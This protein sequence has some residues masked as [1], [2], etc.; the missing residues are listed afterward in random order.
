MELD[1]ITVVLPDLEPDA[2]VGV[3]VDAT[4]CCVPLTADD[5]VAEGSLAAPS[6]AALVEEVLL[7]DPFAAALVAL[8]ALLLVAA[9]PA[10]LLVAVA[11]AGANVPVE[12]SALE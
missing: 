10:S 3:D 4:A 8:V 11:V 2:V 12:P 9:A 6:A 1:G 5:V 7:C